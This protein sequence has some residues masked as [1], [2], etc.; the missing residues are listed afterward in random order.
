MEFD[1]QDRRDDAVLF[2]SLAFLECFYIGDP[3]EPYIR[4]P[5]FLGSVKPPGPEIL[6]PD[7]EIGVPVSGE[8]RTFNS[9]RIRTLQYIY[10]VPT[11]VV[12]KLQSKLVLTTEP[13][14]HEPFRE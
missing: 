9:L 8:A 14:K 11:N 10:V 6:L 13:F 5:D 4:V 7:I 3:N 2:S 1:V 12:H